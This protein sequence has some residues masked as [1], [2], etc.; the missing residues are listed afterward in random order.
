MPGW[1]AQGGQWAEM[2][3]LAEQEELAAEAARNAGG[4]G[5]LTRRGSLSLSTAR[6]A[7]TTWLAHGSSCLRTSH[8]GIY[9]RQPYG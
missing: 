4:N 7:L 2:D 1:D 8:F 3:A 9:G 5:A 6:L